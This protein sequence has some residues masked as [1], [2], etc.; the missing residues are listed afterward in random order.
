MRRQV[1]RQSDKKKRVQ[2]QNEAREPTGPRYVNIMQTNQVSQS[3]NIKTLHELDR[4]D[5]KSLTTEQFNQ[6]TQ[7]I[8]NPIDTSHSAQS[9]KPLP[10]QNHDHAEQTIDQEDEAALRSAEV[11]DERAEIDIIFREF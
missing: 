1:K 8:L 11:E 4:D 10:Q 5:Y 3:P 6:Y 7:I 9:F 2:M